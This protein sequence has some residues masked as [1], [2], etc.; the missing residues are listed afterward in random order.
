M[1]STLV[2]KQIDIPPENRQRL[3]ELAIVSP[4]E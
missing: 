4:S 3:I 1:H 2:S